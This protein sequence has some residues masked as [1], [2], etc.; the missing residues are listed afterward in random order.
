MKRTF[1][2]SSV[3]L[4][5]EVKRAYLDGKFVRA[6]VKSEREETVESE[7][8]DVVERRIWKSEG[9]GQKKFGQG[10]TLLLSG[11]SNLQAQD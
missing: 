8:V 9:R 2:M 7:K 5:L 4:D 3:E 6:P 1:F 10:L 11:G